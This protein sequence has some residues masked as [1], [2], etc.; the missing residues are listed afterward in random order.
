MFMCRILTIACLLGMASV[1]GGAESAEVNPPQAGV[2][3]NGRTAYAL[4]VE[5]LALNPTALTVAGWVNLADARESQVFLNVGA[6]N[7]AFTFYLY[8]KN[9]RM[10]VAH[11]AGAYA[12]ATAPA[13]EPGTWVHYA[14]SYDGES[15]RVYRNGRL[16]K[17]V[18]AP[19]RME[20][21]AGKLYIGSINDHERFLRGR[22]EDL[23][24]WR[25]VL[26]A[27]EIEAVASGKPAE[28]LARDLA[29]RWTL[30]NFAGDQWKT[31]PSSVPAAGRV[32]RSEPKVLINAKDDG[33]RGIWYMNQPS[34]DEYVYKY[35]GGLGTYCANHTPFAWYV[36]AV[37]KT[38]FVYGGTTKDSLSRLVH[39][40][41]YYDH[42]TG[43]VPRPTILLDKKTDDAHD[44]PVIN[45]DDRGFIWVFS[46]SHGRSRPSYISRSKKP[47]SVDEFEL[48]WTG[49]FSYPQPWPFPGQGFLFLH[50]F[51]NPGR[52]ICMMTS[53]DG[54]EWT[55]RR[56]L[57]SIAQGH[58][59]VSRPAP[60]GRLGTCF[61]YHPKVKGLNWRTNL[62][63][64]ESA[65]FGKTWK[66]AGGQELEIPL[67]EII[68]PAL[69]QEYE[70]K[71][72]LV[73][74]QDLTYDGDGRPVILYTTSR[75]YESGPK[76]MPRTWT[77]AR[78]T[79]SDW[80]IHGGDIISDNNYDTGSL[81]IEAPDRWR[82]I[83]PTEKGPQ[84]YNTGGEVAMWISDNQGRNWK[85]AR[86]MTTG[87]DYNHTYVR[88]P[89]NAH[90]DF[91]AF[92][93]D[94]HGRQPSESRLYF[95]NQA[96]D[97]FRL[98]VE[99]SADSAQP[100]R[101]PAE[102]RERPAK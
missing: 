93:A 62:Y 21:V 39:M 99:M 22:M 16:V 20:G 66:S 43:T 59:Q 30:A 100:E 101:L 54:V 46:S 57:S 63:Y 52:T 45:V 92:W 42:R 68:N 34:N 5:A 7:T 3:F 88:Q 78:W 37:Q 89:V 40:V 4:P 18:A 85:L 82:I 47:Y 69:V 96:G 35:S 17:T 90:P 36:E 28:S 11:K 74:I 51:Y 29:A 91:Y 14:G 8:D 73:Y 55:E 94:G 26:T 6:A 72:L 38:F 25:R 12:Y 95:C 65:D 83:G 9:V 98:P 81:Y 80:E 15:I 97:V 61:M 53:P 31:Q 70:S 58:Y 10:L 27:E 67:T 71:G 48:V 60:G 87:S 23:R 13:P 19:G 79:G 44:N 84:A 24:V 49:N 102:S 2:E 56:L 77:T 1:A 76:N 33:Y 50:T 41:S 75:G 64:M 86:R 32:E